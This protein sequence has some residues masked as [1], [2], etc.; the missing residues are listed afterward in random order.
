MSLLLIY[1]EKFAT[2]APLFLRVCL[3]DD[4]YKFL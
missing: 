4:K 3:L 2:L 1:D